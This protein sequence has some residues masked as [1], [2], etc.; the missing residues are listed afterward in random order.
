MEV[1]CAYPGVVPVR[2]SKAP[3]RPALT[4][5]IAPWTAFIGSVKAEHRIDP[6]R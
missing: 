3:D 4:F 1:A 5:T 6:G 2:D